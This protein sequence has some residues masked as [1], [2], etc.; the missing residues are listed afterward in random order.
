MADI[1]GPMNVLAPCC[2]VAALLAFVWIGVES[3]AGV[4]VFCVLYGSLSTLREAPAFCR[5]ADFTV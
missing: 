5:R 3:G 4:I 2:L 1:I